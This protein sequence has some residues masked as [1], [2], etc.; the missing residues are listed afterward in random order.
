MSV[1]ESLDSEEAAWYALTPQ[2]RF[3]QYTRL[4]EFY[5][6]AGGTLAPERDSQSPFDFPEYYEQ[7]P[8]IT[9]NSPPPATTGS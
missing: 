6:K 3:V 5:L 9:G 4:L 7:K 1:P 2:E 8:P